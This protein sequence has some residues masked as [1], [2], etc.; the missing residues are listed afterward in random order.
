MGEAVERHYY[1][2]GE[3][4][5]CNERERREATD[6]AAKGDDGSPLLEKYF[7]SDCPC[8]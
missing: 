5:S 1:V 7:P 2:R 6:A 4:Y 8:Q 3:G